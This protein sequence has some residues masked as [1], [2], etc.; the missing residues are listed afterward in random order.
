MT[1]LKDQIQLPMINYQ[2]QLS[3]K[4]HLELYKSGRFQ[5]SAEGMHYNDPAFKAGFWNNEDNSGAGL[6]SCIG[7]VGASARK[8][9]VWRL[10][11]WEVW[12]FG[13]KSRTAGW[14]VRHRPRQAEDYHPFGARVYLIFHFSLL[15]TVTGGHRL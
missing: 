2:I 10:G 3:R 5:S 6:G 8:R 13:R 4:K 11:S 12:E 9:K 1:K 7:K 14:S 15:P